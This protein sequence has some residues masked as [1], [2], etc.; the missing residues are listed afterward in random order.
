MTLLL[1]ILHE[2]ADPLEKTLMLGKIEGRR[3]RG[4]QRMRWLDG[5]TDSM[6]MTLSTFQ[7]LV[8]DRRAAVH[9]VTKSRTQL[10]DWTEPK[11]N[12]SDERTNSIWFHLYE[13]FRVVKFWEIK[14]NGKEGTLS[15][16]EYRVSFSLGWWN[17]SGNGQWWWLH[18]VVNVLKATELYTQKWLQW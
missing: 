3:R 9:G 8:M 6:D 16:N 12:R 5:I 15:L 1:F 17:S 11:W 7:E 14:K 4:W 13:V 18:R 10:S 2:R